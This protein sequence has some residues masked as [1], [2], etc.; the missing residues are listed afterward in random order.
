MPRP[1]NHPVIGTK[2]VLKSKLDDKR[3][4]IRNKARLVAKGYSQ[5][6]GI[7]YN[8]TYAP[9]AKLEVIRLL[10]AYVCFHNFKLFRWT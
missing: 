5:V 10:L 4:V 8:E 6:E 9:V 2:R 3:K 1:K 7:D